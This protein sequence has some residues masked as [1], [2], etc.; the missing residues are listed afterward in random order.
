MDRISSVS[1]HLNH[2]K[3]VIGSKSQDDIVICGALRTALGKAKRGNLKDTATEV[4]LSQ[5]FNALVDKTGVDKNLVEDIVVGNVLQSGAAFMPSRMAQF[6]S[7]FPETTSCMSV[8]RLCSS[9]LEAISIIAGKIASGTIEMGIGAGVESMSQ[10]DMNNLVNP[11]T[12]SEF[13]FENE[14]ARNC[15]L[16]M[17]ETS[18]N[19]CDEFKITRQEQDEFALKSQEKAAK[20]QAQGLFDSEIV[21]VHTKVLDKDGEEKDIVVSKD[22][23][24]RKT[25]METLQ[26]LKP[27]FRKNGSTTAGNSSQVTD[28]AAAV[29]LCKRSK[30]EKLG[31]PIIAKWVCYATAGVPPHV[32]GIGP[33]FAIPVALGKAG[34]SADKVDVFEINEAFA[35]QAYYTCKK[36]G[37][38]LDK[39]NPKGGAI[40]LGHPLGCTGARQMA[41]ILPELKRTNGKIGVLSMCIGTGMGAAAVIEME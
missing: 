17:G 41:T 2:H 21:P 3:T 13:V 27:A 37:L 26:K 25:T 5:V 22:E 18:E 9:G 12:L 7:Q 40:A 34:I 32:M 6:L 4:L 38:N 28:G 15:M 36:L 30:A 16:S 8:N 24:I 19:V 35:S 33:A 39:V 29:L 1:S 14:N 20:A 11:E 10:Y 23:G 31:L